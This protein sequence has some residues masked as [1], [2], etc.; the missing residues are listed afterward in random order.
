M[1]LQNEPF[2]PDKDIED[3]TLQVISEFNARNLSPRIV[4]PVVP[5][6]EIMSSFFNIE[7]EPADLIKETNFSDCLARFL[8]DD[9]G[10]MT[11]Q[12]EK[13]LWPEENPQNLG[14]YRF[15]IAHEIM[16][17]VLHKHVLF[18]HLEET[19]LLFGGKHQVVLC[20][21]TRRDRREL[22]ADK[23]A[24]YLLM[25]TDFV[26]KEWAKMFGKDAGPIN[27]YNEI[28]RKAELEGRDIDSIRDSVSLEFANIF[29]VS[30]HTMQ[31]RLR[32][33]KLLELEQSHPNLF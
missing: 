30:A 21:S 29:K 10:N 12:I 19:P 16:H 3:T 11:I 28:K 27:V 26:L 2:I 31:I 32:D 5:V 15:T 22:Q 13:T 24:A 33:M 9:D 6:Y 25:P 1:G 14:R 23:G 8:V 7:E 4:G 17:L 18:D 20:R